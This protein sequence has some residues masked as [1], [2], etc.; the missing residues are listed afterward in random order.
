MSNKTDEEKINAI[1]GNIVFAIVL[2]LIIYHTPLLMY[3]FG[4]NDPATALKI[5]LRELSASI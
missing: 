1:V 3:M 2:Y 5:A 4:T